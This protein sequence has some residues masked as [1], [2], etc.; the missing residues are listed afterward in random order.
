MMPERHKRRCLREIGRHAALGY[1][2]SHDA[3]ALNLAPDFIAR[4][5]LRFTVSPFRKPSRAMSFS[6][7]NSTMR[8]PSTPRS[9]SVKP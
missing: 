9:R 7:M 6:F 3:E 8:V 1:A 4:G 5:G 2:V